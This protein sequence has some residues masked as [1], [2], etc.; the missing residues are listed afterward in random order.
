[1]KNHYENQIDIELTGDNLDEYNAHQEAELA[2]A[3][4]DEVELVED[5][6]LK[7]LLAE[8]WQEECELELAKEEE[9]TER[10]VFDDFYADQQEEWN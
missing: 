10:E 6:E 5:D 2:S 3:M 9:Y 4:N 8:L 7:E 1:M